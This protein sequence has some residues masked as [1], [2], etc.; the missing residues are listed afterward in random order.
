M[1][2]LAKR[3]GGR[4]PTSRSHS[5]SILVLS[6]GISLRRRRRS[7]G[8]RFPSLPALPRLGFSTVP[9]HPRHTGKPTALKRLLSS[10]ARICP[11]WAGPG[12]AGK[13]LPRS[14]PAVAVPARQIHNAEQFG[15]E[16]AQ[17]CARLSRKGEPREHGEKRTRS[18]TLAPCSRPRGSSTAPSPAPAPARGAVPASRHGDPLPPRRRRCSIR[19]CDLFFLLLVR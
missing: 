4:L 16:R 8:V 13:G 12:R 19:V 2:E 10:P 11:N 14:P 7:R 17:C 9:Q 5:S 15:A 18:Q 1:T 3:L 6:G